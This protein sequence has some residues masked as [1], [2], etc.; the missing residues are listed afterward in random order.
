MIFFKNGFGAL[1]KRIFQTRFLIQRSRFGFG[2]QPNG[3][4]LLQAG[5]G[6]VRKPQALQGGDGS[7][8]GRHHALNLVIF[9]FGQ[10]QFGRMGIQHD[11]SGRFANEVI[12]SNA[13]RKSLDIRR[14]EG[15]PAALHPIG[16]R[17]FPTRC[18]QPMRQL[19][20]VGKKQQAGGIAI[21]RP[22]GNGSAY[23]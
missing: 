5:Q 2:Q 12:Y 13:L 14:A 3:S 21:N 10:G 22:T 9:T 20:V 17:N 8:G 15:L 4:G 6:N 1:Q 16:L 11:Q 18:G 23:A 19:P 7:P